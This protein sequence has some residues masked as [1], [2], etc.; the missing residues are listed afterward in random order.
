MCAYKI[1]P[2]H[3]CTYK[4]Q[5][6]YYIAPYT[7]FLIAT[8]L[9]QCYGGN[10]K[11]LGTTNG[12]GQDGSGQD[13]LPLTVGQRKIQE[14]RSRV[15]VLPTHDQIQGYLQQLASK[16]EVTKGAKPH[17]SHKQ[18]ETK[19]QPRTPQTA[20]K[21]ETTPQT[22]PKHT[23]PGRQT[24]LAGVNKTHTQPQPGPKHKRK[25][26]VGNP[27]PTARALRQPVPCR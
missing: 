10:A 4:M 27:V 23:H 7:E 8:K 21:R 13:L 11:P 16:Y 19:A 18:A 14:L 1:T 15:E 5:R 17:T 6:I 20:G 25:P 12:R 9:N 22:V 24:G 26:T 3:S 2:M